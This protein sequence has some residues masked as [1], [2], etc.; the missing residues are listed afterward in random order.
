M[1]RTGSGGRTVHSSSSG[2]SRS[3]SRGSFKSSSSS[4][5]GS[6]GGRGGGFGGRGGGFGSSS[7]SS[8]P[9]TGSFASTPD[10]T[11]NN[12]QNNFDNRNDFRHGYAPP[13]PP[14]PPRRRWGWRWWR[15]HRAYYDA[16][17]YYAGRYRTVTSGIGNAITSFVALVIVILAIVLVFRGLTSSGRIPQG[18]NKPTQYSQS[19]SIRRIKLNAANK[20]EEEC[21]IDNSFQLDDVYGTAEKLKSFY[22]T[23]GVQP[24]VFITDYKT[25]KLEDYSEQ[26]RQN[27]ARD[28][29]E[30]Y[31]LPNHSFLVVFWVNHENDINIDYT[32]FAIGELAEQ[33]MDNEALSIFKSS[34]EKYWYN[35]ELSTDEVFIKAFDYAGRQ[36]MR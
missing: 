1:G 5:R 33:V 18:Y 28:I 26:D 23:T 32:T 21:L 9:S 16:D 3:G 7:R 35:E 14:P 17:G 27:V 6:F 4:S 22:N 30:Q 10:Y 13:P 36:I 19:D 25:Y 24:Y 15:P 29:F 12:R 20:F 11:P 2:S 8:T 31:E 34:M